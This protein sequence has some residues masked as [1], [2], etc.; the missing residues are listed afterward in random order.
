[1]LW[2]MTAFGE[3]VEVFEDTHLSVAEREIS[4]A[5]MPK[6]S[7]VSFRIS[8]GSSAHMRPLTSLKPKSIQQKW[9]AIGLLKN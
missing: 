3:F 5:S 1:M 2:N 6:H 7:R 9:A 8:K 4:K